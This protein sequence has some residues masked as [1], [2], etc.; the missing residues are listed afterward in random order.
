[1]VWLNVKESKVPSR[2][3]AV[4]AGELLSVESD[5]LTP[6]EKDRGLEEDLTS[7][8]ERTRGRL[9]SPVCVT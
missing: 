5:N 1:M 9:G 7:N 3:S 6:R 2:P 4:E 8:E